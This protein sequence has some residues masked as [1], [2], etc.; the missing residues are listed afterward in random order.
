MGYFYMVQR[1]TFTKKTEKRMYLTGC[2]G[3]VELDDMKPL[4]NEVPKSFRRIMKNYEEYSIYSSGVKTPYGDELKVFCRMA[5]AKETLET[6]KEF[7]YRPWNLKVYS[8]M[9]RV[10]DTS[11]VK[12][13]FWWSVEPPKVGRVSDWMAFL[14]SSEEDFKAAIEKDYLDW[15]LLMSEEEREEEYIKSLEND[16]E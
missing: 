13:N 3:I 15:W 8:G 12:A 6:I 1:G 11:T 2:C 14:S 7:I 5:N 4:A 16:R 10:S 9:E